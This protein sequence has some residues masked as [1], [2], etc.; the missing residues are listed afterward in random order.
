MD[1]D[2]L[3]FDFAYVTAIFYVV[4]AIKIQKWY[5][6]HL[7]KILAYA[8]FV[9][10]TIFLRYKFVHING[11]TTCMNYTLE[12]KMA[13][14]TGIPGITGGNSRHDTNLTRK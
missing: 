3:G 10:N 9:I 8:C 1:S 14:G 12:I 7:F 6:S 2:S 13:T 11:N 4:I 5:Q